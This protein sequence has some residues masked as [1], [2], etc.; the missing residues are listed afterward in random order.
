MILWCT[1]IHGEVTCD[2]E[3][4]AT[5]FSLSISFFSLGLLRPRSIIEIDRLEDLVVMVDR[6]SWRN[7]QRG[8]DL[9][10]GAFVQR[11]GVVTGRCFK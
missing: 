4:L 11:G 1:I 7:Y 2:S 5:M 9:L 6:G 3:F 10:Q 8:F